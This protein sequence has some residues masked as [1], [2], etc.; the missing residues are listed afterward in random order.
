MMS[1]GK[2]LNRRQVMGAA[3][4]LSLAGSVVAPAEPSAT[5]RKSEPNGK[6]LAPMG[7]NLPPRV[8]EQRAT[9]RGSPSDA[10]NKPRSQTADLST[11]SK[12][13]EAS[14]CTSAE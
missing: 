7:L 8:G 11:L 10:A 5:S 12:A 13:L 4:A 6:A 3:T 9:R 1:D 2:R 14:G